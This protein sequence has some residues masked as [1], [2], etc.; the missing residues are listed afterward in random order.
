MIRQL[1]P[2][3]IPSSQ[4]MRTLEIARKWAGVQWTGKL[5]EGE[6]RRIQ[7]SGLIVMLAT[8]VMWGGYL[9][10]FAAPF[11]SDFA[12]SARKALKSRGIPSCD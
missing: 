4:V 7:I 12:P 2:S 1:M 3:R 6:R 8:D 10:P 5:F 9:E 11:A